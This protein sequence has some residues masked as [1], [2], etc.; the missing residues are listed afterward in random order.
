MVVSPKQT[1]ELVKMARSKNVFGMVST[2]DNGLRRTELFEVSMDSVK[3]ANQDTSAFAGF[4]FWYGVTAAGEVFEFMKAGR[5][6][7]RD[8]LKAKELGCVQLVC[9]WAFAP[10]N[11]EVGGKLVQISKSF[12]HKG[13]AT[14]ERLDRYAKAL[15]Y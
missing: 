9:S 8:L 14:Q 15:G 1:K 12:E 4:R 13:A 11:F 5:I 7:K 2:S 6:A 10:K 3:E